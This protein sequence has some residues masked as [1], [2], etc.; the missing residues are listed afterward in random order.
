M[1]R[2]RRVKSLKTLVVHFLEEE[3]GPHPKATLLFPGYQMKRQ[4][5]G[6]QENNSAAL[7]PGVLVP[8]QGI[9]RASLVAQLVKKLPAMQKTMV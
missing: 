2:Q 5:T 1:Q 3:P 8:L 4:R 6:S 7:E 9:C